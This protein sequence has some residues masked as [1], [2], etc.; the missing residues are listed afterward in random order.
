[1]VVVIDHS[2]KIT[3]AIISREEEISNSPTAFAN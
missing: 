2:T 3:K 1:V